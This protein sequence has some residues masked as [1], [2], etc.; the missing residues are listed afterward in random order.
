MAAIK[1]T[2]VQPFQYPEDENFNNLGNF[3]INRLNEENEESDSD[4]DSSSSGE[5]IDYNELLAS[6]YNT[7]VVADGPK[8]EENN[9]NN[10]PTGRSRYMMSFR[11]YQKKRHAGNDWDSDES[12]CY[13]CE[14][15]VYD[16]SES[17]DEEVT[18][19]PVFDAKEDSF[20]EKMEKINQ[21]VDGINEKLQLDENNNEIQENQEEI[22]DNLPKKA[23]SDTSSV[24]SIEINSKTLKTNGYQGP[25]SVEIRGNVIDW[26]I[27]R[28]QA[29]SQIFD[30]NEQNSVQLQ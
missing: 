23:F 28:K 27:L 13:D 16:I 4:S 30:N 9:D 25:C 14:S 15:S 24:C 8:K 5:S 3:Q 29:A 20:S 22:D 7:S 6:Y 18:E 11:A 21:K 17:E 26:A 2:K 1:N 12:S 19:S 10:L